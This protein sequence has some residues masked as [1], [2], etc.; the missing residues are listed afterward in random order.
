MFEEWIDCVAGTALDDIGEDTGENYISPEL[1][2]EVIETP[3]HIFIKSGSTSIFLPKRALEDPTEMVTY[4]R[5]L[6][7]GP[8]YFDP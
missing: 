2:G 6:A 5:Q 4:L 3:T 8:Y 7:K 1:I